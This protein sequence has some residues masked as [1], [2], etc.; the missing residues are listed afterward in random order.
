MATIIVIP[1][2]FGIL[3]GI[4]FGAGLVLISQALFKRRAKRQRQRN[5]YPRAYL[6]H[7]APGEA[8]GPEDDQY[9][10][11]GSEI[12]RRALDNE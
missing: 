8:L 2:L 3:A 9:I 12:L 6:R 10:Q 11:D 7:Y 1:N 4:L 5:I